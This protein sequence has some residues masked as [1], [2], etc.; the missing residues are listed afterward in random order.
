MIT[1][2]S[3]D[4]MAETRR[5]AA[6]MA[7]DVVGYSR[8]MG[9]DETGTARVVREHR[10]AARPLIAEFGGRIVKTM[11]DGLLLEFPSAVSAVE[12]A[13][14][15]Q[16]MVMTLSVDTL[17]GR[18]VVYRIGVNL[19]DVLIDGEDTLGDE[20]NIAARLEGICG[21]CSPQAI[22]VGSGGGE[23]FGA[24]EG[25]ANGVDGGDGAAASGF[26]DASH[27]GVELGGPFAAKAVGHL[28]VD[29]GR[30]Q[31]PLRAVV[32]GCQPPVGHEQE[33]MGADF[34][35]GLLQLASGFVGG[36]QA[37]QPAQPALKIGLVGFQRAVGEMVAPPSDGAGPFQQSL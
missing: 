37:Q 4:V 5:L 32:C 28:S 34:L 22:V 20:V 26:D 7:V 16:A 1:R 25:H 15:I 6:I 18:R 36:R 10:N 23:E 33:Q 19:G 9:E 24:L 12:C 2:P 14:K 35:E 17:E 30:A 3:G 29:G 13:V 31:G 8:L 21:N 27:V 11:G